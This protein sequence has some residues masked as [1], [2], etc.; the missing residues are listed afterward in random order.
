[1]GDLPTGAQA[2]VPVARP[3]LTDADS[4]AFIARDAAPVGCLAARVGPASVGWSPQ[5]VGHI[6]CCWVEPE[7]RRLG[8]GARLTA[9]AEAEFRAR[10]V[11][12]AELAFVAGNPEAEAVWRELGYEPHRVFS[13]KSLS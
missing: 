8:A 10:G 4:F 1:M 11:A 7:A 13:V 2:A 5:R 12:L 6:V 9:A 3:F